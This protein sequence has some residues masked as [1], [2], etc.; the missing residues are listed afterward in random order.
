MEQGQWQ[1]QG[2]GA[3]VVRI[4]RICEPPAKSSC[5][6][7]YAAAAAAAAVVSVRPGHGQLMHN[8]AEF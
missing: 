5:A 6:R 2:D 3:G 4:F 8:S 1:W 7:G